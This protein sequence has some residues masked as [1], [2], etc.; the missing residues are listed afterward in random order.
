MRETT[1]STKSLRREQDREHHV[2]AQQKERQQ[3]REWEA[4]CDEHV[5]DKRENAKRHGEEIRNQ[6]GRD[7]RRNGR[8]GEPHEANVCSP[9]S[10][11]DVQKVLW[12]QDSGS[13]VEPSM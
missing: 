9:A 11:P 5:R 2:V 8:E 10:M 12:Q 13:I 4:R 1:H 3:R 7:G 6:V